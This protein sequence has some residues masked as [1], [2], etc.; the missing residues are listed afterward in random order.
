MNYQ[1][2]SKYRKLRHKIQ[3]VISGITFKFLHLPPAYRIALFSQV[4]ILI[5]LYFPW[6][7][8]KGISYGIFSR[9]LWWLGT[10]LILWTVF[11]VFLM[12]SFRKKE[13]LK[14]RF[15]IGVSDAIIF[16]FFWSLQFFLLFLALQFLHSFSFFDKD[17]IF[18]TAPVFAICG[19]LFTLWS[20]IIAYRSSRREI[21]HSLYVENDA[22]SQEE[23][24]EYKEILSKNS[25]TPD[26]KNM[27]LP[28]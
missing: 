15:G 14:Q 4:T 28:I 11:L 22:L 26:K 6:F 3:F 24:D 21:L 12:F 2:N 25:G 17:I 23:L 1:V 10:L 18:Y 7:S 5:S 8:I 20:G 19:S 27:A 9:F 13:H 16:I